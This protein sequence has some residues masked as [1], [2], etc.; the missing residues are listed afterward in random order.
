MMSREK[1]KKL[2]EE[3]KELILDIEKT[4]AYWNDL[5]SRAELE[6]IEGYYDDDLEACQVHIE[7]VKDE[8]Q[9]VRQK[10]NDILK[11]HES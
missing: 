11:N 5:N 1:I 10:I 6:E 9:I 3:E 8:L 7:L 4:E 2:I